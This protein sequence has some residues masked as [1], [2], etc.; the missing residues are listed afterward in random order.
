MFTLLDVQALMRDL[1]ATKVLSVYVETRATDPAMRDAWRSALSTAL[2]D[3]ATSL[4]EHEHP[5]FE[6][7]RAALEDL[8]PRRDSVPG[9]EGWVAFVTAT[10]AR[11]AA[12]VPTPSPTLVA[13]R[14]GPVIA[15][16]MRM[17]KEHRPVIVALVDSRSARLYRYAWGMLEELPEMALSGDEHPAPGT[18]RGPG[19]RGKAFPAPRSAT[20]T[21]RAS[22]RKEAAFESLAAELA[23]RLTGLAGEDGWILIGGTR[24]WARLAGEAL[25][26]HLTARA[27]VSTALDQDATAV[28]ITEAAQHAATALRAAHGQEL[29]NALLENAGTPGRAATG[30]PA[31][32][33]ALRGRA[34]DLLVLS[35][36][37]VRGEADEAEDAVRSALLHGAEVEVL[38]GDAAERLDQTANGVGARL[39]FAMG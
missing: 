27:T 10:G 37:F 26:T 13:W 24:E 23:A 14:E 15:P 35:P 32:Q 5:E 33:R 11:H 21:E 6:R 30:V 7:A 17:L 9:G 12:D 20:G 1:A 19:R 38:S 3:L 25:P 39:R 18:V 29:L 36:T 28:E 2:R 16:Y 22:R 31:V 8:V 4:P 34:V